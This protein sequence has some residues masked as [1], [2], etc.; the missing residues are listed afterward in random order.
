MATLKGIVDA[1]HD[2]IGAP[3]PEYAAEPE[4]ERHPHRHPGRTALILD[5]AGRPYGSL[6]EVHPRV[7]EAW[8][9]TGRPVD[10]AIDLARLLGL[11]ADVVRAAPIPAA[12][13][14]DRD[15][16]VVVAD[17]TPV[18][19]VLRIARTAAGP[20][21]VDVRLFDVYRGE[22]V[23]TGRVSYA[24]ALRF[25]PEAG[26]VKG[27]DQAFNRVRGSLRHHLGAEIRASDGHFVE[28][29]GLD[30]DVRRR[31]ADLGGGAAHHAGD[32][33]R[34]GTVGDQQVLDV[35]RAAPWRPG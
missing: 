12:Q 34:T 30:Q 4:G 25:Q 24:L 15:L 31:I 35:E 7:V 10:A 1:L 28:V 20:R 21:L 6:G 18:G 29:R 14:V 2:A 27:V 16:A 13:P 32:A 19:E 5:A 11:A 22:Q 8:G 33:D 3:R 23:G 9:L 17:E 26:D